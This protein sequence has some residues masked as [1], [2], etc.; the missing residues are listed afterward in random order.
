MG[1]EP[2]MTRSELRRLRE[3]EEK[4]KRESS[5]FFSRTKKKVKESDGFFRKSANNS[6]TK[7][8]TELRKTA[9]SQSP[10]P[11]RQT[12]NAA[13]TVGRAPDSSKVVPKSSGAS[14]RPPVHPE[15][16]VEENEKIRERNHVLNV[17]IV[18]VALLLVGLIYL[19]ITW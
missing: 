2:I 7:P 8:Q 15:S 4:K 5:S 16:R 14:S 12:K 1:K 6:G 17:L 3:E 11:S 19:V 13:K 10:L 9:N 18:L